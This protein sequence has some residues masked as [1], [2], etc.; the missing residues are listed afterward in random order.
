MDSNNYMEE[1]FS[2]ISIS[3]VVVQGEILCGDS[4]NIE[5]IHIRSGMLE[6]SENGEN[7]QLLPGELAICQRNG[8]LASICERCEALKITIDFDIAPKCLSCIMESIDVEPREIF[9]RLGIF[10]RPFIVEE[11]R[12]LSHIF[13]EIYNVPN[14]VR[15]GYFKIKILELMLFLSCLGEED[16]KKASVYENPSKLFV[17]REARHYMAERM[18]KKMTVEDVARKFNVSK[19]YLKNAFKEVYG[20]PVSAVMREDKM[21]KAK[22]LLAKT[23]RKILDIAMD[24]GYESSGKFSKAF[25]NIVGLSPREYRINSVFQI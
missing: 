1:V 7:Y 24:L 2:G 22:K 18:G 17:V 6:W 25:K 4:N 12:E 13:D 8:G 3:H 14:S 15:L 19:S 10:G 9:G 21:E 20:Q 23:D 5:I 11:R 16:R